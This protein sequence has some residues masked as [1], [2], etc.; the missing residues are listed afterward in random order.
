MLA[1]AAVLLALGAPIDEA[2]ITV[3]T[4]T[5]AS[6]VKVEAREAAEAEIRAIGTLA[7]DTMLIEG[8]RL[9][10][11][12]EERRRL[13]NFLASFGPGAYDA[14]ASAAVR[15]AG[16]YAENRELAAQAV[17]EMGEGVLPG[18]V[19]KYKETKRGQ[20]DEFAYVVLRSFGGV[21]A[22]FILPLA[23]DSSPEL[24]QSVVGLLATSK[25]PVAIDAL[26]KAAESDNETIRRLGIEGLTR[27]REPRLLPI[28]T[29]GIHDRSDSIRVASAVALFALEPGVAHRSQ[30]AFLARGDEYIM[31]RSVAA[32]M[33]RETAD[34]V[35]RRLG[36]RYDPVH[37][38]PRYTPAMERSRFARLLLTAA[39]SL[40]LSILM[41]SIGRTVPNLQAALPE[42]FAIFTGMLLCGLWWGRWAT[43][44]DWETE[45]WFAWLSLLS[46][47]GPRLRFGAGPPDASVWLKRIWM[48]H[49][50]AI[51]LGYFIGWMQLWGWSF[52]WVELFHL[53]RVSLGGG[54]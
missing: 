19:A 15:N 12:S 33:L 6:D 7:F 1:L 5:I 18:I 26:L 45:Y 29:R 24:R 49:L 53:W 31:A 14:L 41:Y 39:I 38:S 16:P 11:G 54:A 42:Q 52:Q 3:L 50:S 10:E 37:T 25:N 47:A 40:G 36:E 8:G 43:A 9:P 27:M 22:P 17:R 44:I 4:R 34:P 32:R 35:S 2:R 21:A 20:P 28:A 30:L 13:I 23:D 46:V 48:V 51:A